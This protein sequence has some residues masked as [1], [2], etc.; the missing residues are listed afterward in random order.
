MVRTKASGAA[1]KRSASAKTRTKSTEKAARKNGTEVKIGGRLKHARLVLGL[2]LRHLADRLGCSESFISKLENDKVRPSLAMLH[3]I[4]E[5][6]N[7]NIASLFS[8][9]TTDSPV[10]VVR[11]NNRP[12]IRTDPILH[13]PGIALECLVAAAP[14]GL[15]DA[16]IHCVEPGGHT[17]GAIEHLGEE[18]GYVLEGRLELN[19]EGTTYL[20]EKGDCFFFRSEL[21]HGYRN[22]GK[23]MTRVLWVNTPPTF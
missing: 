2:R 1:A 19:V 13:G 3:R 16:N 7:I 4:V 5:I 11:A 12:V 22:P 23:V 20:V 15:I 14:G 10:T 9:P 18:I 8:E 6:L 17:D 21:K